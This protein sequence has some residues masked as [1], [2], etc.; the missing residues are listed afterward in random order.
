MYILDT[1]VV[2]ELRKGRAS[3]VAAWAASVP[4]LL[5][6]LSVV[7]VMELETGFLRLQRKDASQTAVLAACFEKRVLSTF[8]GRILPVNLAVARRCAALHVPEPRSY[9][10][11]LIVATA[12]ETGF[13]VATRNIAD[14]EPTGVG[15]LNPWND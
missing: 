13:T 1:N 12:L 11:A 4:G 10:D 15:V 3:R 6:F 9:R 2:F 14:F 7:T 8:A 5:M